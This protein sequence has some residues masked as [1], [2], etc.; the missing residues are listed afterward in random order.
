MRTRIV[1]IIAMAGVAALACG[2]QA[3]ESY[4]NVAI[5]V[6]P[7]VINLDSEVDMLTVH[8]DIPLRVVDRASLVFTLDGEIQLPLVAVFADARGDL[9]LKLTWDVDALG[10]GKQEELLANG[11]AEFTLDGTTTAGEAFYG[12]CVVPVIKVGG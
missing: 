1:F 8:S 6:S 9:V 2:L 5:V 11:R 12:G 10:E 7:K 3:D 4:A